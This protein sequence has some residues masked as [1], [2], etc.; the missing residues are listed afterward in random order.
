[1]YVIAQCTI[2]HKRVG[3]FVE[4]FLTF[5]SASARELVRTATSVAVKP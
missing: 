1:M 4:T 2:L 3:C 5:S